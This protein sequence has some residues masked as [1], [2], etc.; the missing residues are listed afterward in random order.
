MVGRLQARVDRLT[1]KADHAR[2]GRSENARRLMRMM[3]VAQVSRTPGLTHVQPQDTDPA[4]YAE[5]EAIRAAARGDFDAAERRAAAGI[6]REPPCGS[7]EK[8]HARLSA[9]AAQSKARSGNNRAA[10]ISAM[11]RIGADGPEAERPFTPWELE[12]YRARIVQSA[13]SQG[14]S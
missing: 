4:T 13:S 5:I 2:Q 14:D 7:P 10:A 9:L 12:E 8:A 6:R 3:A 1:R 11:R